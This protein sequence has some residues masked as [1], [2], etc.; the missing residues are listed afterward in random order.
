MATVDR[1]QREL[2]RREDQFLD[3][4]QELIQRDGLLSL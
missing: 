2:A 3:K 1:K 4:A